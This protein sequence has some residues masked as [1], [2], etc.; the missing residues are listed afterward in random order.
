V[1]LF[2]FVPTLLV[3]AFT[4]YNDSIFAALALTGFVVMGIAGEKKS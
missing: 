4:G 1:L 3:A 2:L